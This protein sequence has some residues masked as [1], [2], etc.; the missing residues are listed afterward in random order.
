MVRVEVDYKSESFLGDELEV[1]SRVAKWGRSTMTLEQRIV[2]ATEPGRAVAEGR[3]VIVWI[4]ENRRPMRV[5]PEA[6]AALEDHQSD[7][8]PSDGVGHGSAPSPPSA[9]E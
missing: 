2:K 1:H 6:R 3:V 9:A 4:G 7:G 5:P 8:A